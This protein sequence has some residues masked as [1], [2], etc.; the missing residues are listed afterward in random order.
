MGGQYESG[1]EGRRLI[2]CYLFHLA[3]STGLNHCVACVL[4]LITNFS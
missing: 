2:E 4:L 1:V 3:I